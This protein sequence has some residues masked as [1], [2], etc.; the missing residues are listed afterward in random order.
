MVEG[1]IFSLV[2]CTVAPGFDFADFCLAD[3]AALVAAFPQHQ[4]IIQALTR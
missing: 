4:Q 1:G 2:G 3:R